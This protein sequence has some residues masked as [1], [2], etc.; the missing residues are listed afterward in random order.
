ML[1]GSLVAL[2]GA[3]EEGAGGGKGFVDCGRGAGRFGEARA[4]LRGRDCGGLQNVS[5]Q[6]D[7]SNGDLLAI[8]RNLSPF[9]SNDRRPNHSFHLDERSV[10]RVMYKSS[11]KLSRHYRQRQ[12]SRRK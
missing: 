7:D 6:R 2:G 8:A 3:A 4:G 9:W 10:L 11:H 1:Y 5:P 12:E